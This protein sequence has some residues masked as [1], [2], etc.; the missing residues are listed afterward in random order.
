MKRVHCL[1]LAVVALALSVVCARETPPPAPREFELGARRVQLIVPNGWEL[2]DQGRQKRFRK[3][4]FEIVLESLGRPTPADGNLNL[5]V[6]W[7]LRALDHNDERSEVKSRNTSVIDGREAVDV[8][9]WNR[10]DHSNP[11]RILLVKDQDDVLALHTVRMAL[12][13]T[14]AAFDALRTSFHFVSE[15]R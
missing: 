8:E 5:L 4:E 14:L 11:R 6:E 7:A 3:G 10:L 13:D 9:T 15:R 1:A 2:L 12:A